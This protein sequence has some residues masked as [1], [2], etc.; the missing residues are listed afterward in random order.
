M[1]EP[2]MGE[3]VTRGPVKTPPDLAF[4]AFD[5]HHPP[6]ND[7]LN[8]CV[9]C[10]FC[11]STCPT[12][13]LWGEEMDSPRGRIYLM[14]LGLEGAVP[15]DPTFVNHMDN[16]LG[17]MAC[18][19]ACPSG[20]K[21]DKLIEATRA[22]IERNFTRPAPDGILRRM[23]FDIFPRPDRMR[24]LLGP[25][26]VYQRS[27]LQS[28]L[29]RSGI[30]K[31]LPASLRAMESLTPPA[32]PKT[33]GATLAEC[34]A[35][36]G[37]PRLRVGMLLGCVQSVFFPEVNAATARVLA[38]EGCEVI[39]P[40]DQGCCGALMVHAGEEKAALDYARHTI[41]AFERVAVDMVVINAAGCGSNMKEYGYL[42]R[43][44]TKYSERAKAFS[45]KCRDI[46]EV[47]AGLKP[48]AARHP[49]SL[50]VAYHDA[51]HLQHAQGVRAQPRAVLGQ[52]PE[53]QIL[54]TAEAALCCGSAGIYNLVRPEPAQELGER[55]VRHVL[56][57]APDIVASGNPGCL[58][59][60]RSGLR[61][62]GSQV[63]VVHMVEVV[64][65]SIRGLPAAALLNR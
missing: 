54:E 55:K 42:L 44:D 52:I 34:V 50:K 65:A 12:Y 25:L 32:P 27:G 11:L 9:H 37:E 23:I 51:C 58:L 45:S 2:F 13:A 28:L 4:G 59:Q 19:T 29:R 39:I 15:L 26:R 36:Q 62:A 6:S 7:L 18:M 20:V 21:Y 14:K 63:P 40:K 24:L 48:R 43:D 16:C 64:D 61:L 35:A 10:G 57:T 46:S 1:A 3:P 30:F 8:E 53:L 31:L 22:Q 49:L 33:D 60:L 38:A 47:L 56:D 5:S 17:C 41:D